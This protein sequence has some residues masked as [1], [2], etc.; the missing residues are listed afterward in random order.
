MNYSQYLSFSANLRYSFSW[1][2]DGSTCVFFEEFKFPEWIGSN[3]NDFGLESLVGVGGESRDWVFGWDLGEV[4]GDCF[5]AF[6][7]FCRR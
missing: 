1:G 5:L 4:M 2:S 7:F 6:S 3:G